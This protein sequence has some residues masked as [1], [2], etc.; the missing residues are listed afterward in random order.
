MPRLLTLPNA[1]GH[2]CPA[3]Y[4]IPHHHAGMAYRHAYGLTDAPSACRAVLNDS[5]RTDIC[6]MYSPQLIAM[7][8]MHVASVLVRHNLQPWL[9]TLPCDLDKVRLPH[10]VLLNMKTCL[11]V[12]CGLTVH[13]THPGLG[14]QLG[15]AGELPK[16]SS[17]H[18]CRHMQPIL[19]VP[20]VDAQL[21]QSSSALPNVAGDKLN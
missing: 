14:S 13:V 21:R 9:S 16:A 11:L 2:S 1:H 20:P 18:I 4:P 3:P 17:A 12:H 19:G 15:G 7:A 8:C 6:V 5:Y 10:S